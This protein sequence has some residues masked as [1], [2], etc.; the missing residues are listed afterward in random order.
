MGLF[1]MQTFCKIAKDIDTVIL[2]DRTLKKWTLFSY[3]FQSFQE[4]I[5][6]QNKKKIEFL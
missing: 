2:S 1:M 3:A 6:T 4:I 5:G